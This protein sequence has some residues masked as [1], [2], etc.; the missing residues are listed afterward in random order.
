[1]VPLG[2]LTGTAAS[3]LISRGARVSGDTAMGAF[4]RRKKASKAE[5]LRQ[6]QIAA[7]K[8]A[9]A[10]QAR[11]AAF[12]AVNEQARQAAL[13]EAA[14]SQAEAEAADAEVKAQMIENPPAP[15]ADESGFIE[16]S[17]PDVSGWG[18]EVHDNWG[19]EIMGRLE[20]GRVPKGAGKYAKAAAMQSPTGV[21]IRAGM[22]LYNL[23]KKNPKARKT[24]NNISKK[25]KRGDPQAKRD[26]AAIKA[27]AR[28]DK[29]LRKQAARQ[30]RVEAKRKKLAARKVR[31]KFGLRTGVLIKGRARKQLVKQVGKDKRKKR[32]ALALGLRR[33]ARSKNPIARMRARRRIKKIQAAANKGNPKAKRAVAALKAV[34]PF[35]KK[36]KTRKERIRVANARRVV[37][38]A[39]KGNPRARAKIALIQKKAATGDKT[40]KQNLDALKV[41]ADIER[42]IDG[43]P[44]LA[45]STEAVAAT[46]AVPAIVKEAA[47]VDARA[48]AGDPAA[49]AEQQAAAQNAKAG[50]AN[51]VKAM[52]AL[53]AARNIQVNSAKPGAP[54]TPE[55]RAAAVVL[56]RASKGDKKAQAHIMRAQAD[57]K[58]GDPKAV[59][60]LGT[61]TAASVVAKR[62]GIFSRVFKKK[63]PVSRTVARVEHPGMRLPAFLRLGRIPGSPFD[64]YYRGIVNGQEQD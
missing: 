36:T 56:D 32:F 15:A 8:R 17:D 50:D 21:K 11:Q 28:A 54:V 27:G 58:T 57:A 5:I 2:L 31:A 20:M 22:K 62:R 6:R 13:A 29:Q 9:A 55:V 3:A 63:Q 37:I 53:V 35:D 38:A 14:A 59:A 26:M 42:K 16:I 45:P 23:A 61:L 4:W 25:A 41:A 52:T 7:A 40:A 39:K 1:M 60:A 64:R 48:K 43:A 24:V 30:K 19:A 33:K 51:A 12:N 18:K 46:A 44:P 10:A 34:A 49:R 47:A